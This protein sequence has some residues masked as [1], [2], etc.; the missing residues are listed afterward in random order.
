MTQ[1]AIRD[2]H[3]FNIQVPIAQI[4]IAQ[5]PTTQI[6][7]TIC[8]SLLICTV[9]QLFANTI[10]LSSSVKF[11]SFWEMIRLVAMFFHLPVLIFAT[12][13]RSDEYFYNSQ[14]T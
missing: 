7:I 9:Y 14:Y 2:G 11:C 6:P 4:P 13:G 12:F 1:N 3:F 10:F 5:V 8:Q